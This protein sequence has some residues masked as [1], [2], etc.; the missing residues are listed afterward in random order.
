MWSQQE[1]WGSVGTGQ[2][3]SGGKDKWT[4]LENALNSVAHRSLVTLAGLSV[5]RKNKKRGVKEVGVEG[6]GGKVWGN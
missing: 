1:R 2:S 5:G 6:R 3:V 4:G